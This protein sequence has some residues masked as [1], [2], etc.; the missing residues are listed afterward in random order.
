LLGAAAGQ[1]APARKATATAAQLPS[2]TDVRLGGD[3]KQT[4][5]VMDISA[6]IDLAAFTLADPYRVVVDLPQI[7]FKL[8]DKTGEQGR[9][10]VKAF[11]FGLIMQGGSRIVLDTKGP[12]RID[13]AFVLDAEGGQPARLVIDM[14]VTDKTSF[15]RA[16]SLETRAPR[17]A[18]VSRSEAP[19]PASSDSRPL[20][21]LDPGHGGIDNGAKA[22]TGELEKDVVLKFAQTLRGMLERSGKYRVALTRSDD[23]FIALSERVKFSRAQGA[24]L[25]VSIHADAIPK[26]EGQAEGATV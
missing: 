15:Q 4:R 25:F 11:R 20:V 16:M 14:S 7:A 23:T 21:V 18:N 8:P 9:G 2:A 26:S 22:A 10:L 13:K 24:S 3:D 6:K 12:V 17:S 5:F 19:P 1:S